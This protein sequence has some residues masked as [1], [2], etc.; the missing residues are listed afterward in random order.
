[1]KQGSWY[2]GSRIDHVRL[3][4]RPDE[5]EK[6]TE[7]PTSV[8]RGT[9]STWTRQEQRITAGGPERARKTPA[10]RQQMLLSLRNAFQL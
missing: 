1:M 10:A 2:P 6:P 5:G 9:T 4:V 3:T 7:G 8:L